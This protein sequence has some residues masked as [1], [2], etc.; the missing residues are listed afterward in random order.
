MVGILILSMLAQNPR[1]HGFLGGDL[2][3]AMNSRLN[4]LGWGPAVELGVQLNE[5]VA[6]YAAGRVSTLTVVF[7]PTHALGAAFFE[8]RTP[9]RVGFALGVGWLFTHV[10]P[11][12]DFCGIDFSGPAFPL[13][14]LLDLNAHLRL[15]FEAGLSLTYLPK[16]AGATGWGA[17]S[18]G[19]CWR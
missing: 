11:F 16:P 6:I 9:W 7:G 3:V 19:Y 1:L 2:G 15:I 10:P 14:V 8:L 18:V 13:R 5:D 12:V 17:L 4:S